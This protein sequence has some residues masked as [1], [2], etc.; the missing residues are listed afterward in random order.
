MALKLDTL[1]NNRYRIISILGQGGMGAVYCARDEH[2]DILVAVKENLFLSDEY[3][4]QFQH[5]ANILASLKHPYLPRVGDYFSADGEGQYLIMDYVEGED[6]RER[7]ERVGTL[8]EREALLIG[9]SVCEALSYMHKCKPPVIHRDIKPGNIKITPS[10]EA[11]LVDFGLAKVMRGSQHTTTGARAMTPGY[12][13]PEQY[14][15]ARTD[16]RSDIYSLGATL[17]AALTGV[18]PEDSLSRATGKA[19]LTTPRKLKDTVSRATETVLSKALEIEPD[20]RYQT[21]EEFSADLLMAGDL[22]EFS[23]PRLTVTPP[24]NSGDRPT[25][26]TEEDLADVEVV[27]KAKPHSGKKSGRKSGSRK[28]KGGWKIRPVTILPMLLIALFTIVAFFT[29]SMTDW[30][31]NLIYPQ[32]AAPIVKTATQALVAAAD[33]ATPIVSVTEDVETEIPTSEPTEAPTETLAPSPTSTP[34]EFA[35]TATPIPS[36]A[37]SNFVG[38]GYG[39]IAFVSD[40]TGIM[41]IWI[42]NSDGSEQRQLTSFESGACQPAWSP[43]GQQLAVISPCEAKSSKYYENAQIYI[44]DAE[45]GNA[46]ML[47]ISVPGDFDPAWSPEGDKIAFSSLRN[48]NGIAHIFVYHLN[49][50]FIEELSDTRYADIQ[51][52]WRPNSKQIAFVREKPYN[53]VWVMSDQGQ[54]QFQLSTSGSVHDVWPVWTPDGKSILYSRTQVEAGIPWLLVLDYEDRGSAETRIPLIGEGDLGPVAM[55][56]ISPDGS[57]ISYESWPDGRNHDIYLTNM[58]GIEK[59]RLTTDPGFDFDP[60]WRPYAP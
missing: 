48:D 33:T 18:I 46:R 10:G 32:P 41:Q 53:H 58:E 24:P 23:R 52:V 47:P 39:Q 27:R 20:D 50:Q 49:D 4:R 37:P 54:T 14:G 21:A 55:P 12:S 8:S 29:P 35:D 2:L 30:A 17:Y 13:P 59:I 34:D 5:E 25:N 31:S 57:W 1:L 22:K 44:I 28:K 26:R 7:I 43:N 56:D 11:V 36:P 45:G 60:V 19:V 9:V 15:T 40:R 6:L 38:G 3:A 42:M 51:P 16:A